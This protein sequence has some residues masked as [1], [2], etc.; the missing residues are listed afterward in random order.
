M[1]PKSG[2]LSWT[3]PHTPPIGECLDVIS[4]RDSNSRK[5]LLRQTEVGIKYECLK[6]L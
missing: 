5:K 4:G 2:V 1:I 3:D 6:I